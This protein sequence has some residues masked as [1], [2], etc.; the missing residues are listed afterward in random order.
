[1]LAYLDKNFSKN[2]F[3]YY[4]YNVYIIIMNTSLKKIENPFHI[5]VIGLFSNR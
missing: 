2:I 4:I 5:L 1:M 3:K